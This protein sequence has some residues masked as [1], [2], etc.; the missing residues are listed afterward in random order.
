MK[1]KYKLPFIK[2]GI[3]GIVIIAAAITLVAELLLFNM[4]TFKTLGLKTVTVAE[5]VGVNGTEEYSVT[6]ND[7]NDY[8]KNIYIEGTELVN[9]EY[10]DVYI[11]LTDEGDEYE[12]AMPGCRVVPGIKGSGYINIYPYGRV[13]SALATR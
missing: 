13:N 2:G 5:G 7:V 10:A 3:S 12:Y 11:T 1:P 8:V 9:A 6:L 4:S